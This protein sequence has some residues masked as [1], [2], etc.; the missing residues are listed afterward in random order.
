MEISGDPSLHLTNVAV[1]RWSH[2]HVVHWGCE[3]QIAQPIQEETKHLCWILWFLRVQ[4]DVVL[5]QQ[6][7]LYK[8]ISVGSQVPRSSLGRQV[9]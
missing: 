3:L 9:D 1:G 2:G 5:I 8:F 6:T 7:Q 4:G